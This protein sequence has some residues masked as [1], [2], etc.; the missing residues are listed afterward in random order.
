MEG[1]LTSGHDK[2]Y[3]NNKPMAKTKCVR[4]LSIQIKFNAD[5]QQIFK[6][7]NDSGH[8][9]IQCSWI[10][11]LTFISFICALFHM[12]PKSCYGTFQI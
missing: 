3:G 7:I 1:L 2:R 12:V 4:S 6:H 8:I 10:S 5:I 11:D 9:L